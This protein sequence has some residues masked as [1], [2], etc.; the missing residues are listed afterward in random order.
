MSASRDRNAPVAHCACELIRATRS[1]TARRA[2][3]L[4]AHFG[5]PDSSAASVKQT[6]LCSCLSTGSRGK[7]TWAAACRSGS[8]PLHHVAQLRREDRE[9]PFGR[10][11]DNC[12]S[13]GRYHR[14]TAASKRAMTT[15]ASARTK[16]TPRRAA[17]GAIVPSV[18]PLPSRAVRPRVPGGPRRSRAGT[19][20]GA[21][22]PAAIRPTSCQRVRAGERGA[23]CL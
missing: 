22:A 15:A 4:C 14:G 3:Q 5:H 7:R 2:R 11:R 9:V 1:T 21:P 6:L 13:Q 18:M 23:R 17:S 16:R 12:R 8:V 20:P 10:V 19:S